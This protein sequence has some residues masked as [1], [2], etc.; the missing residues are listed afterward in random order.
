MFAPAS[1]FIDNSDKDYTFSGASIGGPGSLTKQGSGELFLATV[2]T[3]ADS[4]HLLG[5]TTRLGADLRCR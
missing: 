2:N 5:G 3:Y 1:V 4:T